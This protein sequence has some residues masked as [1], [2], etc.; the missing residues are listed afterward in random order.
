MVGKRAILAILLCFVCFVPL[1]CAMNSS[2][3]NASN[4]SVAMPEITS[5]E[6][7]NAKNR[8]ATFNFLGA[9]WNLGN[10]LDA[11]IED[12][13]PD[14]VF[15]YETCWQNPVITKDIFVAIKEG[16]FLSVRIPV[17]WY[18]HVDQDHTIDKVWMQRVHEVV[19]MA[20][21]SDLNVILNAHHE[22]WYDPSA[23]NQKSAQKKLTHLWTQI[24]TEFADYDERL[25]FESMNEPRLVDTELEWTGG[26]AETQNVINEINKAFV[27]TVRGLGENNATRFLLIPTYCANAYSDSLSDLWMPDDERVGV[28]LHLY[29]PTDFTHNES[30]RNHWST[31][32]NSD[33]NEIRG[34]LTNV[35]TTFTDKGIP[36][37]FTEIGAVDKGNTSARESWTTSIVERAKLLD[38]PCF[39]W[40]NGHAE[41][42][43]LVNTFALIDRKTL[44]WHAPSIRDILVGQARGD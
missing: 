13:Q 10:S 18:P 38:I 14:N 23:A 15:D 24:A 12:Y 42:E 17:T 28:S 1:G 25:V 8:A 37:V 30:K 5:V 27:T 26:T 16:G 32:A 29:H 35:K 36:V 7:E 33:I 34:I 41:G 31:E 44:T 21:D 3:K 9:G 4:E 40:D 20:L 22:N 43:S 6:N 39:W 2:E 11:H 19:D